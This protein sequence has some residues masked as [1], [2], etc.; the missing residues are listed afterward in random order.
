MKLYSLHSIQTDDGV[1]DVSHSV[2]EFPVWFVLSIPL[3][4]VVV[5]V[6][7]M[8]LSFLSSNLHFIV[9]VVVVVVFVYFK[10]K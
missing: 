6:V 10:V 9:V 3:V 7:E 5:V 4:V 1:I 2:N 8:T